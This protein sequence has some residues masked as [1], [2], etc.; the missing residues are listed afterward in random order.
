MKMSLLDPDSLARSPVV[1]NSCMNR[2][3]GLQGSNGYERELRFA[4]LDFLRSRTNDVAW[5][6]WCCG[7]GKAL[8]VAAQLL[9]KAGLAHR[10][11]IEGIDLAGRFDANPSPE[12]LGLREVS[13]EDWNPQRTFDLIT[14]VH[15]LHYVGDK[16]AAIAKAAR[17]L[18]PDGRFVANLD[19]ADFRDAEGKSAARKVAAWLRAGGLRYDNRRKLI[20]CEGRRELSFDLRY[21]GADDTSGPN[22][23]GQPAIVSHY[24]W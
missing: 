18:L 1:A 5:A 4:I 3:R 17:L 14:C 21:L 11:Q 13:I 23:T 7:S 2:E 10:V 16:L 24:A 9:R 20:S 6:D 12:I 15:G 19:V 8:I 22:Y